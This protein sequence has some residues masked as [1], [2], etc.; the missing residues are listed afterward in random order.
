MTQARSGQSLRLLLTPMQLP[1][2][3]LPSRV[4]ETGISALLAESVVREAAA[5]PS[6]ILYPGEASELLV[7]IKNLGTRTLRLELQTESTCPADWF[8]LGGMEGYE[9]TP[10]QQ[11]EAVLYFQVPD[12]F[13]EAADALHSDRQLTIDFSGRIHVYYQEGE[14]DRPR[15]E[16]AAF[17][18]YVRPRSLYLNFLPAIYT[19]EDFVGRFLKIFEQA[20]EPAVQALDAMW[21]YL[22]PLTAPS[23]MLPFL[24]YWVA[25]PVEQHWSLSRQRYLI[26]QAME[27]YRWRGTRRGLRLYLHL[28]TGLPLD[29]H[30][31]READ[32]HI[33]IEE[34]FG[35]GFVLSSTQMGE[36][37][38]IGGG[39][40]YHFVVRLRPDADVRVDEQVVRNI[41]E[42]EKPAFCT[43]ELYVEQATSP[44]S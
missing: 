42:R 27:I 31:P 21:A 8:R 37:S 30:I 38:I 15:N 39:Q 20:F 29:E 25:W 26:R 16:S 17:D 18:L 32:K 1:D 33:S 12:N 23:S 4:R 3:A 34:I 19:E 24:S 36:D 5:R 41:I 11:I 14:T 2:A 35:E 44:E 40:P 9:L 43:Y 10:G 7:Q 13:F 22:D 6:L 28:Y